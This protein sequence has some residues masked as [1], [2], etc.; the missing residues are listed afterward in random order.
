M[1]KSGAP[2]FSH[3]WDEEHRHLSYPWPVLESP[4]SSKASRGSLPTTLYQKEPEGGNNLEKT[5]DIL[6]I[7][8][9]LEITW[10]LEGR[11]I[12]TAPAYSAL[13]NLV[14]LER[15][16]VLWRVLRDGFSS[17]SAWSSAK[18]GLQDWSSVRPESL[19][20]S[21]VPMCT[22]LS[23]LELPRCSVRIALGYTPSEVSTASR[24]FVLGAERRYF[25]RCPNG[26]TSASALLYPSA[27]I[28]HFGVS[29]KTFAVSTCHFLCPLFVVWLFFGILCFSQ[30]KNCLPGIIWIIKYIIGSC[31][32]PAS[33]KK[34]EGFFSSSRR[35][36]VLLSGASNLIQLNIN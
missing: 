24:S 29:S 12:M 16:F 36:L 33:L 3:C 5:S 31:H 10:I 19:S 11:G 23:A 14:F 4:D 17:P 1:G 34:K 25:A 18:R 9:L 28:S 26:S 32:L 15:N 7:N 8:A 35:T 20:P 21:P 22:C 30:S 6:I 2:Y 27:S 13:K